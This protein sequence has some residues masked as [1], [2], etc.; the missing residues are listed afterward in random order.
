MYILIVLSLLNDKQIWFQILVLN[1]IFV[2]LVI[3]KL[4]IFINIV[5]LV[6]IKLILSF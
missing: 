1:W 4:S 5:L 3:V 6:N 2:K